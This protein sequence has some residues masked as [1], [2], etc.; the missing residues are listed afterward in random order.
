VGE[1][2]AMYYMLE[3]AG[4]EVA[5]FLVYGIIGIGVLG[6]TLYVYEFVKNRRK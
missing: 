5:N 6:I 3:K 2:I 1:G 4:S